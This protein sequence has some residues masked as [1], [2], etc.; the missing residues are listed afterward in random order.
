MLLDPNGCA[1]FFFPLSD[2]ISK[3]LTVNDFLSQTIFVALNAGNNLSI[4]SIR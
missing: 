1:S 2:L 3:N 4:D